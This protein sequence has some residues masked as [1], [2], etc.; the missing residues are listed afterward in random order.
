MMEKFILLCFLNMLAFKCLFPR[1]FID[2]L[3]H[4]GHTV[5][6]AEIQLYLKSEGTRYSPQRKGICVTQV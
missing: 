3:W 6:N 5:E 1:T 2:I 4:M